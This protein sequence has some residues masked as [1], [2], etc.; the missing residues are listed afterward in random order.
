V[1]IARDV[2]ER[3]QAKATLYLRDHAIAST[4][5]GIAISDPARPG[6]RIHDRLE[7]EAHDASR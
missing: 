1:L 6:A 7:H 4:S 5:E 3:E 2:T